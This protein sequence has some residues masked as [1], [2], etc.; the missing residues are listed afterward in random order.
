M[1][2]HYTRSTVSVSAYCKR[3]EKKT[4]H[5]VDGHRKGP[6]LECI[7]RLEAN[8]RVQPKPAEKQQRLFA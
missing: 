7:K 8:F 3:C 2:E 5:R 1:G 4:Q 6:C